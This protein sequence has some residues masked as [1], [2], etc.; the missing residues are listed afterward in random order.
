MV[1]FLEQGKTNFF[2]QSESISFIII[3][4]EN[5]CAIEMEEYVVVA[6][7]GDSRTVLKLN[8]DGFVEYLPG[9]N[10]RHNGPAACG[11]YYTALEELVSNIYMYAKPGGI[12]V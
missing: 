7:W 4:R 11:H 1:M 8:Q 2:K 3:Y 12:V 5:A 9:M 10:D 6:G